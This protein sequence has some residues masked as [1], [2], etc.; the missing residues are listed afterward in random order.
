[1]VEV[2]CVDK[3]GV[4][5]ELAAFFAR[6]QIS[7]QSLTSSKY[8]AL[9]SG[10]PMFGAQLM[11]CVPS[12]AHIATLRDEFLEFCDHMNLDAAMDPLKY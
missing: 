7:V 8:Q 2:T 5:F 9:H 3:P 12:D 6:Q 4:V 11:V 1:M 10:V